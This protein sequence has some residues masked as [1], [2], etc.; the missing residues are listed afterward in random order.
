MTKKEYMC[1]Y[2]L[3]HKK[4]AKETAHQ[5]YLNHKSQIIEDA[6]KRGKKWR[7]DHIE[8]VRKVKRQY[9]N[10]HK[11][12]LHRYRVQYRENHAD[13]IKEYNKAYQPKRNQRRRE[14]TILNKQWLLDYLG[15]KQLTC[16]RCGYNENFGSIDAHHLDRTQK[17]SAID[18]MSHWLGRSH[19]FFIKKIMDTKLLFLCRN[20]HQSLNDC[21]WSI[22]DIL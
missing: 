2:R 14:I 13:E 7:L 9:D 11:A 19:R 3:G 16:I 22:E 1:Q 20:C 17:K 21:V 18:T 6:K 5:Y 12:E 4:R 10:D 8:H 15:V